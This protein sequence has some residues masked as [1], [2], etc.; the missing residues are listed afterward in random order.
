MIIGAD[1]DSCEKTKL[2]ELEILRVAGHGNTRGDLVGPDAVVA[3]LFG[4][5][6]SHPDKNDDG[7][8]T[9]GCTRRSL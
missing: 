8:I 1:L 7:N 9:P 5:E 6:V 2:R 3:K 4:Q